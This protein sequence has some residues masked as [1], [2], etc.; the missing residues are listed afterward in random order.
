MYSILGTRSSSVHN[1]YC[2]T[3]SMARVL[4]VVVYLWLASVTESIFTENV[5]QEEGKLILVLYSSL[6]DFNKNLTVVLSERIAL[7]DENVTL[8]FHDLG[9]PDCDD[10]IVPAVGTLIQKQ[11]FVENR[12]K[13]E[14][15]LV[16]PSCTDSAY[17]V[18]KLIGRSRA[19]VR[20][21]HTSPMPSQLTAEVLNTSHGL[22][23]PSDL[24]ANASVMLIEHANWSQVL[25]LYQ[26]TV[27]DMNYMFLQFQKQL[28]HFDYDCSNNINNTSSSYS[29]NKTLTYNSLLPNIPI[30][31]GRV[32]SGYPARILFL[33]LD[34]E[35]ARDV[36]CQAFSLNAFY[37]AY[38]WVILDVTLND[39]LSLG[40]MHMEKFVC[41]KTSLLRVLKRALFVGFRSKVSGNQTLSSCVN[42]HDGSPGSMLLLYECSIQAMTCALNKTE[43]KQH[44]DDISYHAHTET[45]GFGSE[46]FSWKVSIEQI[47]NNVPV[48]ILLYSSISSSL[49]NISENYSLISSELTINHR[50]VNLSAAISFICVNCMILIVSVVLQVLTL[51]FRREKSVKSS[52]PVLLHMCYLGIY[53]LN[54]MTHIYFIQKSF[55]FTSDRSYISLCEM[56]LALYNTGLTL[57]LGTLTMKT[58]RLYKI[59]AHFMN[60]GNFL[61]DVTLVI[62]V[63]FLGLVDIVVHLVWFIFDPLR[64]ECVEVSRNNLEGVITCQS[65]CNS[66]I[67]IFLLMLLIGYQTSIMVVLM[68]LTCS[69]RKKIPKVHTNL[70]TSKSAITLV[71]TL[72]FVIGFGING[73]WVAHY[74]LFN[75]LFEF[76]VMGAMFCLLQ[77]SFIL[78]LLLPPILPVMKKSWAKP[79]KSNC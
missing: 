35:R 14:V 79:C 52:S 4:F 64:R 41:D 24:L 30:N 66:S 19:H 5:P 60:P 15:G 68:W 13:M 53:M 1:C 25:A 58:W 28:E 75:L 2:L 74:L 27:T 47:Q 56:S 65:L 48:Q 77:V 54:I 26:D 12:S 11:I 7:Y 39:I 78:L 21:L 63:C 6:S 61:S 32:L 38:Q 69:V 16:G 72:L 10:Q 17:A 42:I 57:V 70:R 37:P 73:Y 31:L 20:H 76:V 44:E 29:R 9:S 8:E 34:P 22:R 23:A 43:L 51:I 18:T 71:Y 45:T 46:S 36:L 33:M 67:Y 49:R 3:D 40:E 59:F 62:F 50:V 55:V